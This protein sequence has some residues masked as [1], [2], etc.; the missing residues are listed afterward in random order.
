MIKQVYLDMDGVLCGFEK[1]AVEAGVLDMKNRSVDWPTL[2]ALG[3]K[4]WEELE[5]I[6]EGKK[7][8]D[9][10]K[11]FC[12]KH[13]IDLCILSSIHSSSGKEGKKNW[14]KNNTEINPMNVYIVNKAN[15]KKSFADA[16]SILIDD[17]S[18]NIQEFIQA[19][20]NAFKF[21]YNAEEIID[22]I[23]ELVSGDGD[24]E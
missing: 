7:L 17:Y 13:K 22:K 20:G 3:V 6:N 9:F 12:R 16:E 2:K 8:Y 23:K 24:D 18:K 10:L 4:F 5:W 11:T 21:K 1:A 19:G 14:L 15:D